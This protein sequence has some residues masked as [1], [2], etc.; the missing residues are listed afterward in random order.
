MVA[1]SSAARGANYFKHLVGLERT[2]GVEMPLSYA[3]YVHFLEGEP[4]RSAVS[5]WL[6]A[7]PQTM[8]PPRGRGVERPYGLELNCNVNLSCKKDGAVPN[9]WA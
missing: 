4:A 8:L 1:A 2:F 7:T 5:E 3:M 6:A 9:C